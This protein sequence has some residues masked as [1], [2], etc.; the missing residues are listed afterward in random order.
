MTRAMVKVRPD[1]V[2]VFSAGWNAGGLVHAGHERDGI[3]DEI[4]V[5]DLEDSLRVAGDRCVASILPFHED[6]D[7]VLAQ[8]GWKAA[9]RDLRGAGHQTSGRGH[10]RDGVAMHP[11]H[12]GSRESFEQVVQLTKMLG[13]LQDPPAAGIIG[14]S[15]R[16]DRVQAAGLP[17]VSFSPPRLVSI[18]YP[19]AIVLDWSEEAEGLAVEGDLMQMR[20]LLGTIRD[21]F[22]DAP[23]VRDQKIQRSNRGSMSPES[24]MACSVGLDPALQGGLDQFTPLGRPGVLGEGQDP[25][26]ERGARPRKAGDHDGWVRIRHFPKLTGLVAIE[27]E[28]PLP[29]DLHQAP[30]HEHP[31]ARGDFEILPHRIAHR[32]QRFEGPRILVEGYTGGLGD[33]FRFQSGDEPEAAPRKGEDVGDG[34][35]RRTLQPVT[36]CDFLGDGAKAEGTDHST[37][38]LSGRTVVNLRLERSDGLIIELWA[39]DTGLGKPDFRIARLRLQSR[40]R[41]VVS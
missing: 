32:G 17:L 8:S 2:Q 28:S 10:R 1:S 20:A 4:V 19:V 16:G 37:S 40:T 9:S 26:G 22:M 11:D 5:V 13:S 12:Q 3:G 24:S 36:S 21:Q 39:F 18:V 23:Q 33:R 41:T 7:Q 34:P 27:Q 14:W 35:D 30:P 15:I 38:P 25:M 29:Q 6:L 31:A